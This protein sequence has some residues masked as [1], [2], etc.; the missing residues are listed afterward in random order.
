MPINLK[1]FAIPLI[2]PLG[3]LGMLS[4]Q[5]NEP[6]E[7]AQF[8]LSFE[9][10]SDGRCHNLSE[11]GKLAVLHNSHPTKNINFRLTRYFVDVRQSGRATGIAAP[12]AEPVKIGCTMVGGRPQRWVVDRAEFATADAR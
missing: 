11:G 12:A 1:T 6:V 3:M 7:D 4:P 2:M 9:M 10:E 5:A 8:F